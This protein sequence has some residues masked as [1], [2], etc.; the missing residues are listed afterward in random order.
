MNVV[1]GCGRVGSRLATA[2]ALRGD[3]VTIIDP[4][5]AALDRL[6]PQFRGQRVNGDG[7]DRGVLDRAGIERADGLAAVTGSDEIN[8]VVGRLA[9]TKFHV[10][11]VV[12]RIY[13]PAKADIYRRLG[14]QTIAP[15]VWGA[16]RL[17]ELLTFAELAPVASLGAGQVE[18][19][20][21][22]VPAL[23]DGR[24][25]AELTVPGET[26][27]VAITRH[28]TTILAA[29]PSTPLE[30]GDIVHV[31]VTATA[32]LETLLGHH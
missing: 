7:C 27:I 25:A 29:G 6:G 14:V 2:L 4:N 22:T 1:V 19:V 11:R 32:R 10:P 21:A 13:D 30:A 28:G 20:D 15:I 31:A 3:S 24:P 8:A 9:A 18:I 16:D 12:A 17:V 26:T 5:P 23:L